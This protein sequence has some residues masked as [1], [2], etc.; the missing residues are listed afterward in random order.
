MEVLPADLADRDQLAT[1]EA[2][3]ADA[4]RPV[5][6]LVNNAGFGLKGRFLDNDV[7]D[8]ERMLDVLV[9]APMRL[10]P[11]RA[12]RPDRPRPRRRH[13]RLQRGGLPP[14]RHLRRRQGV[15][16]PVRPWA[17]AEYGPRG[18]TVMTLCPGFVKTEFHE[19]MGV[20][21]GSGLLWL[22]ADFL[23]RTALDDYDR[24]RVF[25]VP[26]RAVQGDP[27]R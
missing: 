21:P 10:S 24:G 4:A 15:A 22:D 11:R 19:R 8:E 16:Q 1:V 6:L 17:A 12:P 14:P 7:D 27:R 25:S 18:V 2:R 5:D 13:Q 20:R 9:A 26:G 23:V 3:L